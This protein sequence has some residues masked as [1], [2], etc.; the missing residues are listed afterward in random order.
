MDKEGFFEIALDYHGASA[1]L[2]ELCAQYLL[3]LLEVIRDI[4]TASSI[5]I[6]SRLNDP[7]ILTLLSLF[8]C[9]KSFKE[10]LIVLI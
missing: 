8:L 9:I 5:G 4:D 6:F 2:V 7:D 1:A 3:D 10:P